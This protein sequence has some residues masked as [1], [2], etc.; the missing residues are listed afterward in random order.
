VAAITLRAATPWLASVCP[1]ANAADLVAEA[2]VAAERKVLGFAADNAS[3]QAAL[4][5]PAGI[6]GESGVYANRPMTAH[7]EQR[8]V[9]AGRVRGPHPWRDPVRLC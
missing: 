3:V 2:S 9:P 6:R 4:G 8:L 7:G 1:N 5:L